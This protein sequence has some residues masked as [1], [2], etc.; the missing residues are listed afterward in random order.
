MRGLVRQRGVTRVAVVI[1]A[2]GITL[3]LAGAAAAVFGLVAGFAAIGN[4]ADGDDSSA[5]LFAIARVLFVVG[6]LLAPI[7]AVGAALLWRTSD[8]SSSNPDA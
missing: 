8:R 3:V 7:G 5:H 6:A 2:V 1:A 4:S